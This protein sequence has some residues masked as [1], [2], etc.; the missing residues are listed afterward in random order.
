MAVSEEKIYGWFSEKQHDIC[1][2]I[3][4][5]NNN[6]PH[7]KG[8]PTYIHENGNDVVCSMV[9]NNTLIP[10]NFPDIKLLGEVVTYKGRYTGDSHQ[11]SAL[12][13]NSLQ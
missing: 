10:P 9:S 8:S 3:D 11:A 12:N 1:L 13:K 2:S 7:S 6:N 5:R 4:K